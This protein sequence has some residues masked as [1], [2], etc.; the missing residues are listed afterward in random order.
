MKHMVKRKAERLLEKYM[1]L[2]DRGRMIGRNQLGN[3]MVSSV[4]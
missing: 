1:R 4:I 3:G 2:S